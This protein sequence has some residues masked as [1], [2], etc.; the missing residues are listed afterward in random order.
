M[1]RVWA[2]L[3]ISRI[4]S[5]IIGS[6]GIFVPNYF[7]TR[8]ASLSLGR[9]VPVLFI[10]MCAFIA[11]DL[12]DLERDKVNHP[13]RPL[14]TGRLTT[15]VAAGSYFICL[16]VS[17]LTIRHFID[18]RTAF[19]YYALMAMC[20][21]YTYVVEWIPLLKAPYVAAAISLPVVIVVGCFPQEKRLYL[22][23]TSAF[24]L[25]LARE[26]CM[27]IDAGPLMSRLDCTE[28][29]RLRWPWRPLR[30]KQQQ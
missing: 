6:L 18:P 16:G 4:D 9:A 15:T 13:K 3:Q 24:F 27:D 14:P 11:N 22:V 2:L 19:W 5:A 25:G 10:C 17:L 30:L 26:L 29:M 28:S 8:D 7:R 1:Q 12:D 23:A 20:I 21:S